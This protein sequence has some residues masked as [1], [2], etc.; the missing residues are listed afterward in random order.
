[1]IA[2]GGEYLVTFSISY[3]EDGHDEK[4]AIAEARRMLQNQMDAQDPMCLLTADDFEVKVEP[5]RIA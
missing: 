5:A 4:E 1:M 2:P 3:I